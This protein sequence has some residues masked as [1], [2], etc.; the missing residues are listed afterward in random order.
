MDGSLI[1]PAR[2]RLMSRVRAG[3][4]APELAVRRLLH[5]L[6]HRFRLHRRD[7]PGTPDIVL[8]RYRT[9]I[10]VHGCFWHRHPGCP[11][12]SDPKTR[13]EF[14]QDKF[15]ANVERDRRNLDQ[16]QVLGWRTH[17]VWECE[18][19]DTM[20]LRSTLGALFRNG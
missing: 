16:L 15:R 1:D 7:L 12:A 8:P 11:K 18:T 13:S 10:F 6:G 4:T 5:A 3:H 19:K 9:A 2:S 17:V 14:W 20:S